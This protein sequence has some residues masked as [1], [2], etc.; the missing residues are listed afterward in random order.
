ML[1]A[2]LITMR[3]SAAG[4]PKVLWHKSIVRFVALHVFVA[5]WLWLCFV[6]SSVFRV[7]NVNKPAL[8]Q[9]AAADQNAYTPLVWVSVTFR[10]PNTPL[11]TQTQP[12]PHRYWWSFS[13]RVLLWRSAVRQSFPIMLQ[14]NWAPVFNRLCSSAA[15]ER[16]KLKTLN[17]EISSV[18]FV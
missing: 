5:G 7:L 15:A 3:L 2:L 4:N 17:Q 8:R 18:Y 10:I 1:R 12:K 9:T 14:E 13:L 6:T 11:V 16:K